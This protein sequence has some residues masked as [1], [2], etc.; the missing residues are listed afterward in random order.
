MKYICTY[1][2]PFYLFFIVNFLEVRTAVQQLIARTDILD[3]KTV[4]DVY[5]DIS[6]AI[7]KF[8][9]MMEV[10]KRSAHVTKELENCEYAMD[11]RIVLTTKM[12]LVVLVRSFKFSYSPSINEINMSKTLIIL[13]INTRTPIK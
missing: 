2:Q 12:K 4:A 11:I 7:T 3:V 10:T 8:N 5:R 1:I 9:V 6:F 13:I